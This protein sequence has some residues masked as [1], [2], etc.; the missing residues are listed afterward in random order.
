MTQHNI[1]RDVIVYLAIKSLTPSHVC[2]DPLVYTSC[3]MQG[4]RIQPVCQHQGKTKA[5]NNPPLVMDYL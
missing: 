5:L 3:A 2:D 1:L 4:V